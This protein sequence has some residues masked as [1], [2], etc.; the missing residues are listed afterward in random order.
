MEH[1]LCTGYLTNMLQH[2]VKHLEGCGLICQL[3][4]LQQV[5]D[6]HGHDIRAK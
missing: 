2:G 5:Y 6:E 3:A 1:G 4:S